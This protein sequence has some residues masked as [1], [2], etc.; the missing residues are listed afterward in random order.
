MIGPDIQL[1]RILPAPV[2]HVWSAWASAEAMSRWFKANEG[3][4]A[5]AEADFRVGGRYRVAM[6]QRNGVVFLAF[7]EY[8]SIVPQSQI[9]FSW[10]S[11]SPAVRGSIVTIDLKPVS[12][13]TELTLT[14]AQLP[15]NDIGRNHAQ[16]WAGVL[17]NLLGDVSGS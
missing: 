11:A 1:V 7:G 3:W 8:L 9:V 17:G 13:G 16:G 4:V 14:H 12:G 10:N 6:D 2:Q 15:D 5:K